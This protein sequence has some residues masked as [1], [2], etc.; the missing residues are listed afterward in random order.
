MHDKSSTKYRLKS[1]YS[2]SEWGSIRVKI[3]Q[4]GLSPISACLRYLLDHSEI[5]NV[6]VGV[7]NISQLN[8]ILG[9]ANETAVLPD[10]SEFA[11]NDP[12]IVN[13]NNWP[14]VILS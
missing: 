12:Q 13:P 14:K 9:A 3:E 6:I 1:I 7:S 2:V 10:F 11:I 4:A 5:D 8:G